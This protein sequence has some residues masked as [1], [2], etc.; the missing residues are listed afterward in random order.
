MKLHHHIHSNDAVDLCSPL[1]TPVGLEPVPASPSIQANCNN[2][3]HFAFD[4]EEVREGT[5]E[6]KC[7]GSAE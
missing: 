6:G 7:A 2:V 3:R 4:R 1:S 5:V